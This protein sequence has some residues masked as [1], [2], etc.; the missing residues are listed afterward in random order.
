LAGGRYVMTAD[1]ITILRCARGRRATKRWFLD[2]YTGK[3]KLEGYDAGKWFAA[4]SAEVEGIRALSA[5]L[6]RLERDPVHWRS[7]ASCCPASTR[8]GCGG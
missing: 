2:P 4:E 1:R 8:A 6:T 3:P 7:A 5:L